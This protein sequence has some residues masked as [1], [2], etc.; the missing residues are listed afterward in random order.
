MRKRLLSCVCFEDRIWL[1]GTR[2][3]RGLQICNGLLNSASAVRASNRKVAPPSASIG[4]KSIQDQYLRGPSKNS[5]PR[6]TPIYNTFLNKLRERPGLFCC[7]HS[8]S[9][10]F[11]LGGGSGSGFD[12]PLKSRNGLARTSSLPERESIKPFWA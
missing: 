1:V 3:P 2:T 10:S 6:Y 12:L 8:S 7:P 9:G 5:N 4:K 11:V